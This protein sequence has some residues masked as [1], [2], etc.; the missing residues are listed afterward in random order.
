MDY[1]DRFEFIPCVSPGICKYKLEQL[2]RG[3][4]TFQER[5]RMNP[6]VYVYKLCR[7]V[8]STIMEF[9]DHSM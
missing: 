7:S 9:W 5:G 3:N 6:Y 1:I 2:L 4:A 8:I